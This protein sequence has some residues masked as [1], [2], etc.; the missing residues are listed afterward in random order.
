MMVFLLFFYDDI[1]I[2]YLCSYLALTNQTTYELVRRRRIPYM[3][4]VYSSWS[5]IKCLHLTANTHF[6]SDTFRIGF[7]IRCHIL[8]LMWIFSNYFLMPKIWHQYLRIIRP[9]IINNLAALQSFMWC[10]KYY[11]HGTNF[12]WNAELYLKECI[13]SVM[14]CAEICTTSAVLKLAYII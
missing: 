14:A 6:I 4:L 11:T 1:M 10:P 8:C 7:E 12:E 3:R 5:V 9:C 13:L 2:I